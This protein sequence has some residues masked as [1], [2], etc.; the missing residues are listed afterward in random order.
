M[1]QRKNSRVKPVAPE[2]APEETPLFFAVALAPFFENLPSRSRDIVMARF[3]MHGSPAKTLE[4]IGHIYHITRERVR[5]VIVSVLKLLAQKN[6]QPM[7]MQVA[8]RIQS[9]LEQNSGIMPA[10][11]FLRQL[12]PSVN[13][14]RGALLMLLE[15]LPIVIEEKATLERE[16]SYRLQNVSLV[17]WQKIKDAAKSI[18]LKENGVSH[19][20]VLFD[21]FSEKNSTV[22]RQQFFD[23]LAVAKDVRQNVF[24]QWGLI[25]WSDI[26]PRGTREKAYLVLKMAGKPLHF[27]EITTLIDTYGLQRSAK[28]RSHPQTVHN[29]LIK[30]KR[31]IL[32][33]RG[34]YA[35]SEWGYKRGTVKEVLTE[36]LQKASSPLSREAVLTEVLK[37]RQVKKSTVIINLNTFFQR[38][39]KNA[40]GIRK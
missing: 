1:I 38:V 36:I 12:A 21:R 39:S 11:E 24:G 14:E 19:P 7:F 37:V 29:E 18:L 9:I 31:F 28:R 23:F 33:G 3:G 13:K 5:Q 40:Y 2:V 16:K 6:S 25:E 17:E 32:V 22:S 26:R 10:E 15:C 27:R 4:E 20:D 35:L 34:I 8:S 30:D